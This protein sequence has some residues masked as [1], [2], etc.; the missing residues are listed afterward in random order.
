[1]TSPIVRCVYNQFSNNIHI[2]TKS[3]FRSLYDNS[4]LVLR[5]AAKM[6]LPALLCQGSNASEV[7]Y[8]NSNGFLEAEDVDKMT[9]K[10][11]TI[12]S[13]P[14]LMKTVG[15]NASN[16]IP[17]TWEVIVDRVQKEYARIIDEYHQERHNQ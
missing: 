16:T 12:F 1:M 2:L 7:I 11:I 9:N 13:N 5:E 14:E 4:P 8:P 3:N 10:I 17:I 15:E 6:K